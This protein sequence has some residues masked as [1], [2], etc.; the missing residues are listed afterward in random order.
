M[1]FTPNR[2]PVRRT[3]FPCLPAWAFPLAVLAL[4]ALPGLLSAAEE[5]AAAVGEAGAP[6]ADLGEAWAGALTEAGVRL[7]TPAGVEMTLWPVAERP[8]GD[9][10]GGGYGG[11]GVAYPSMPE[12]ALTGVLELGEGWTGYRGQSVPAGRYALRYLLRPEDGYHMGVSY[13]RDFLVL[14]PVEAD[15]GPAQ[16]PGYDEIVE[17][18]GEAGLSHPPVMAVVPI[19]AGETPAL[20]EDAQGQPTLAL[21]LGDL[22]LGLVVE[23]EG[24]Y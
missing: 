21:G 5:P 13:Y 19:E 7:T 11:M 15:P 10:A 20:V 9:S 16:R 2:F 22:V 17:R 6:P 3:P 8:R 23:G 1:S 18:S 24:E 4:L 12:G 14:V